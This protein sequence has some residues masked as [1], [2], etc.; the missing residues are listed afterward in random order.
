MFLNRSPLKP[1]SS[2]MS[3]FDL[4]SLS[5]GIIG[6]GGPMSFF[7]SVG[8][9]TIKL[10]RL[11]SLLNR[12][13]HPLERFAFRLSPMLV[14]ARLGGRPP[15]PSSPFAYA[16]F[17]RFRLKSRRILPGRVE[18]VGDDGLSSAALLSAPVDV[19]DTLDF[20]D[21]G[22]TLPGVLRWPFCES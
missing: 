16:L 15:S 1:V 22:S 8:E 5:S 10:A 14:A 4:I 6:G 9:V 3:S 12:L 18:S 17:R 11:F 20:G 2:L 13:N 21:V 19:L 7:S